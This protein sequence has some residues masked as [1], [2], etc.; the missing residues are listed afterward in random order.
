MKEEIPFAAKILFKFISNVGDV[1]KAVRYFSKF[2]GT[3][4]PAKGVQLGAS[5]AIDESLNVLKKKLG[6]KGFTEEALGN[7]FFTF[8]YLF[9]STTFFA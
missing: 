9:G 6:V 2:V 8:F 4:T 1:S 3:F 5:L 7:F